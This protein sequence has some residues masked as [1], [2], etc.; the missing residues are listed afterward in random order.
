MITTDEAIVSLKAWYL[1]EVLYSPITVAIRTSICLHLLRIAHQ[2]VYRWI[3]FANLFVIWGISIA[4]FFIMTFQ[5]MPPSYFWE[6]LLG[7]KGK[8]VGV[9]VVPDA[10]IAHSIIS[11]LSDWC[12]GLLPIP[13]LWNVKLN[14]RTK[15][16]V[17]ILLSMG[18][19]Y[20][21]PSL[22]S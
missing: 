22:P 19:M 13:L 16:T 10:T 8:C 3:I 18:M 20:V 11:A 17:G 7:H 21:C 4:Y 2:Q 15:I 12:I 14:I 1:C 5:C 9:N 6:Q